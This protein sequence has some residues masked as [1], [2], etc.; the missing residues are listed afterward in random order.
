MKTPIIMF[1][2]ACHLL[3]GAATAQ[4]KGT[5]P[6]EYGIAVKGIAPDSCGYET[7]RHT[8]VQFEIVGE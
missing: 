4:D 2:I 1:G 6:V 8:D 3:T 5:A 7:V